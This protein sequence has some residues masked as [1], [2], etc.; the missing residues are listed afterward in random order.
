MNTAQH[1]TIIIILSPL[2][3]IHL[4]THS[5]IHII[6]SFIITMI[7]H[8]NNNYNIKNIH[9]NR[10]QTTASNWETSTIE[11]HHSRPRCI[12]HH[13]HDTWT[14]IHAQNAP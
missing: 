11:Q 2:S 3:L 1:N 6:Y 4:L 12:R 5:L 7:H 8:N 14:K 9:N 10:L 13:S